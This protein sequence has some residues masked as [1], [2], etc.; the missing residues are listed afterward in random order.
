MFPLSFS[1][2]SFM[3]ASSKTA[4]F[5]EPVGEET[6]IEELVLMTVLKA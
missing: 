5:P 3:M 1:I 6:T 2:N 4:V